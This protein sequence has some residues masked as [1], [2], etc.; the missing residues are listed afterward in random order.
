MIIR[1][2]GLGVFVYCQCVFEPHLAT[3]DFGF[4]IQSNNVMFVGPV[5]GVVEPMGY[6]ERVK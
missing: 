1:E 2:P 4:A 6:I 3:E 5:G